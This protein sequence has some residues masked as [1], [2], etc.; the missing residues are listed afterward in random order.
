MQK[1]IHQNVNNPTI[2]NDNGV[3]YTQQQ[4]EE[5]VR[6][7]IAHLLSPPNLDNSIPQ[8]NSSPCEREAL[9]VAQA[10]EMIGIS[11]PKMYELLRARKIHSVNVGKKIIV[12]RQSLLEWLRGGK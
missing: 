4:V 8:S 10:A 11:K 2:D 9:T 1:W 7:A 6:I 5:A 12:S 3:L